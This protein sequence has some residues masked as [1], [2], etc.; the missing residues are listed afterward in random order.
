[1]GWD[2][3]GGAQVLLFNPPSTQAWTAMLSV[4]NIFSRTGNDNQSLTLFRVPVHTAVPIQGTTATTPVTVTVPSLTASV[5]P[6]HMTLAKVGVGHDWWRLGSAGPGQQDGCN[7][8]VGVEAGGRWGSAMVQ[9]NEIQHHTDVV[10][11]VFCAAHGDVEFP[12][13]CG[14]LFAGVRA[15]YN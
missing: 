12:F 6:L 13:R 7:W 11:G 15:E 3:E 1:P 10:G 9:F 5:S 4:S 14:I 8:R 2:I